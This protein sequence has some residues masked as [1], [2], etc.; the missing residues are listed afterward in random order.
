MTNLSQF[1]STD[2]R[3]L[4]KNCKY[5]HPDEMVRDR[6]V[7]GIIND[8]IRGK[9]LTEGDELTM[10]RAIQIATTHETTQSQLKSIACGN[11]LEL[12][13]IKKGKKTHSI[14]S[15]SS[16]SQNYDK[17]QTFMCKNCGCEHGRKQCRAFGKQCNFCRKMNHYE[18]CCL[19][20]KK[21]GKRVLGKKV[22]VV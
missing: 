14:P 11:K 7:V 4:V 9:L 1:F 8:D 19:L 17:E 10:D 18:S 22:H 15:R 16:D 2:L 6:I 20:K 13:F 21:G 12:D 3:N 5:D